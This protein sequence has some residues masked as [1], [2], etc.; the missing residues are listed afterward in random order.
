[1]SYIIQGIVHG[2]RTVLKKVIS[3]LVLNIGKLYLYGKEGKIIP[4]KI[5]VYTF[6]LFSKITSPK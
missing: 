6:Y 2:R 3:P 1:M 5:K 4:F